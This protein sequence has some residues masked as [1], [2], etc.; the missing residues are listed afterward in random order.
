[1][2][3]E[4]VTDFYGRLIGRIEKDDIFITAYDFYGRIVGRYQRSSDTTVDFYGR[5]VGKGDQTMG[6]VYKANEL[7]SNVW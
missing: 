1:M 5:I 3:V 4:R 6:L 2:T 7:G